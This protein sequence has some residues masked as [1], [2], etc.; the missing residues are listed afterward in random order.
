[1]AA[2]FYYTQ[3]AD[4]LRLVIHDFST[5]Y[6]VIWHIFYLLYKYEILYFIFDDYLC[7]LRRDHTELDLFTLA[8]LANDKASF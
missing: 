6:Y 3:N 7:I 5:K 4:V 8:I 1:M 2:L